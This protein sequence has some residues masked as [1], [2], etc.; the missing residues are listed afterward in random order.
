M[1]WNG[2]KMV[3]GMKSSKFQMPIRRRKKGR[4]KQLAQMKIDD[5]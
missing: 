2:D 1:R 4:K 3:V 5:D